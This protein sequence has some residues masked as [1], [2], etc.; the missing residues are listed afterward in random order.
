MAVKLVNQNQNNQPSVPISEQVKLINWLVDK[1]KSSGI[2]KNYDVIFNDLRTDKSNVGIM[3]LQGAN[4]SRQY[5][6][7]GYDGVIPFAI[8]FRSFNVNS[9]DTKLSMIDL[10]NQMGIWFSDNIS[11]NK[12]IV[13]YC[14][15]SIEQATISVI[16]YADDSGM[17]EASA[18]FSLS[19]SRL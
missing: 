11:S 18:E 8:V 7:G 17:T 9:E 16:N 12:E 4:K 2:F 3:L 15:N 6:D 13:G 19:Y 14:I 5:V 1:I 10:V